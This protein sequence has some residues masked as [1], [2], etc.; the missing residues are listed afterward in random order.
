MIIAV[1]IVYVGSTLTKYNLL[2][3][4]DA[5]IDRDS[6]ELLRKTV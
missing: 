1:I 2:V 6:L 3:L 5:C 4:L